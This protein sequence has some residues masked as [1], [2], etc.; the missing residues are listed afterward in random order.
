MYT[1]DYVEAF[2]RLLKYYY[3]EAPSRIMPL[4]LL[5]LARQDKSS[6]FIDEKIRKPLDW[7]NNPGDKYKSPVLSQFTKADA[8]KLALTDPAGKH[9]L[10]RWACNEMDHMS[11]IVLYKDNRIQEIRSFFQKKDEALRDNTKTRKALFSFVQGLERI[12]QEVLAENY[13]VFANMILKKANVLDEMEDY[14]L[15][16]FERWLIGEDIAGNVYIPQAKSP[17]AAATLN[18]A[19][20]HIESAGPNAKLDSMIGYLLVH[21]NGCKEVSASAVISE[22]VEAKGKSYDLV[23]MNR[24]AHNKDNQHSD[25][26]NC[27][28]YIKDSLTENGRYYGIVE[29]KFF[30]AMLDKQ[31]IFKE[32]IN[33]GEL[34]YVILLP[35]KYRVSLVSINK[36]KAYPEKVKFVNLYNESLVC[37]D[38][39]YLDAF[40]N[41]LLDNNSIDVNIEE[42]K[43]EE[44]KIHRYFS[45]ELLPK[46]GFELVALR[47][48]LRRITPS[49]SFCVSN[50]PNEDEISVIEIDK[51]L[52]EYKNN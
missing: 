21:G 17:F 29:N 35:R 4:F 42:L 2:D 8:K 18:K 38:E 16:K 34:E 51:R 31:D 47:K 24:A 14:H 10:E 5:Y 3:A 48:F 19:N 26:H 50:A 33:N 27:L 46:D 40:Y 45:Y 39:E 15:A 11:I 30:F 20:I 23:I 7:K 32:C 6:V 1:L 9:M 49:S 28:K 36:A 22:F 12:P 41:D 52:R 25:W 37:E 13:L 43:R 44:N